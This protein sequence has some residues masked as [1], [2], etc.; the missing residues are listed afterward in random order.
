MSFCERRARA[1]LSFS[2]GPQDFRQVLTHEVG[3]CQGKLWPVM[4]AAATTRLTAAAWKAVE[5]VQ[6]KQ[7]P[8]ERRQ[9]R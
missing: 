2:R 6:V 7:R 3:Q 4:T 9:R 5:H 8:S 1:V